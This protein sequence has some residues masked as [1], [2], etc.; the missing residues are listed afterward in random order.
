[1]ILASGHGSGRVGRQC[2]SSDVSWGGTVGSSCWRG[3]YLGASLVPLL[4]AAC[5]LE[6]SWC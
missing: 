4:R 3:R 1:M 6:V 5:S 2:S